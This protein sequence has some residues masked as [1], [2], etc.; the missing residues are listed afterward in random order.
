M[1]D[2]FRQ[3][4]FSTRPWKHKKLHK[5]FFLAAFLYF[6]GAIAK[7]DPELRFQLVIKLCCIPSEMYSA[8]LLLEELFAWVIN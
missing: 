5:D 3:G 6:F 8:V 1:S 4:S 7:S 2:A